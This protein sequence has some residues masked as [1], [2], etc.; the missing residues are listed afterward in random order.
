[1]PAARLVQP[2]LVATGALEPVER[3]R[4]DDLDLSCL[5]EG[6]EPLEPGAAPGPGR[7]HVVVRHDLTDLPAPVGAAPLAVLLLPPDPGLLPGRV[8]A[9]PR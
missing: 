2:Q 7:G 4:D 1:V 5:D 8:K 3:P 6:Q 9:H